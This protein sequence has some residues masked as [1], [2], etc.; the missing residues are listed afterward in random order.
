[1][2]PIFMSIS[3]RRLFQPWCAFRLLTA[4]PVMRLSSA[5]IANAQS[6]GGKRHRSRCKG[7]TCDARGFDLNRITSAEAW[8]G[9]ADCLNCNIRQSV[10]FAGLEEADFRDLHR[11]IDQLQFAAGET[12]YRAGDD[13]VSLF[14][15]RTGLVKLTH[16]LPDGSQRIV[17]LLSKTDV[18]GLECMLGDVYR[19][20]AIAL[21]ATEVCRLPVSSVKR[22]SHGN[23]RLF[24]TVMAHWYRALSDADRWITELSTGTA[25]DRVIRLL[26]WLSE[27]ETGNSCS[28]F[29]REDLGAVLGLTT[30]TASR[31]MAELKR[32]GLIREHS[33]NQFSFDIVAL[34]RIV[35]T[36]VR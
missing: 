19:H 13:G 6:D 31:S 17:R 10:L 27:R 14:T 2:T 32:Q 30:E 36:R 22:L 3:W 16:Y 28:L 4:K 26:L 34:R 15:I 7:S 5:S 8:T 11:P 9:V 20:S 35:E 1:M 12:V 24:H 18:I 33:L 29:S 25:R 23:S 21:Q